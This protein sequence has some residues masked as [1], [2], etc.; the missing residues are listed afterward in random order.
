MINVNSDGKMLPT[1][2][3]SVM[4][5]FIIFTSKLLKKLMDTESLSIYKFVPEVVYV[6]SDS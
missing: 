2:S 5:E 4:L 6:V 3:L 1:K